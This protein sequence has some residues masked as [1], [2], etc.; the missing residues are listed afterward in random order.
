MP[1]SGAYDAGPLDPKQWITWPAKRW[2]LHIDTL[3][4]ILTPEWARHA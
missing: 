2:L 3:A 4:A 1:D